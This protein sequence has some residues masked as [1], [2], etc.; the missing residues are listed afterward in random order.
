MD[1]LKNLGDQQFVFGTF[2][3]VANKLQA[4][5]DKELAD[6][7][8][9]AKQWFLS[10]ALTSLF[11]SPPTLKEVADTIGNS[12]QNVKQVALKLQSK[13][14]LD[15]KNDEK[16]G[17]AIR[18]LLTK[19]SISFWEG[20]NEYGD[21]FMKDVFNGINEEEMSALRKSLNVIWRNIDDMSKKY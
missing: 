16:D 3:M 15:I 1:N 8:M 11:D 18:L 20:M 2:F 19:K 14:F 13:G 17:R 4:L 5:L 21:K 12:H 10:V 7:D 6:Y 9:T